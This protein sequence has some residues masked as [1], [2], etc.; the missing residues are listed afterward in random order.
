L[1][2]YQDRTIVILFRIEL[3]KKFF[4]Q[5]R[6]ENEMPIEILSKFSLVDL[7]GSER[8]NITHNK[9]QLKEGS[10]INKSLVSLGNL[11]SNLGSGCDASSKV[12][13]KL[14]IYCDFS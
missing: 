13:Y 7:A 1:F 12:F 8:A 2:R 4:D 3:K 9:K 10:N 14:T 6:I 5:A 11:I